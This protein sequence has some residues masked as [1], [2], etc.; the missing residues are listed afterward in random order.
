[1]GMLNG[2]I[3]VLLL[4]S[5]GSGKTSILKKYYGKPYSPY[6]TV[7]IEVSSNLVYRNGVNTDRYPVRF[8]DMGGARYWW[9][10][11]PE[12]LKNTD[13]VFLF[14]DV[15][16]HKTLEEAEE[17]LQILKKNRSQFRIILVGN[18]TDKERSRE[19]T[20]FQANKFINRCRSKDILL[21][22]IETNVYNITSFL[23][24]LQKIILGAKQINTPK[25]FVQTDFMV[26]FDKK[27]SS[28]SDIIFN[29]P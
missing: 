6:P 13:I 29:W 8:Y 9:S 19:V 4:G 1:M 2:N 10:W 7:G 26:T 23:K 24:I 18:K 20:I 22:H 21:T 15:T 3:K 14:Y 5:A 27:K 28:W 12:N 16:N 11:I 25:E 17:I